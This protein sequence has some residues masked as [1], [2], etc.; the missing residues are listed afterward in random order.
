M[1]A[2]ND[3]ESLSFDPGSMTLTSCM[4]QGNQF[5]F[6]VTPAKSSVGLHYCR[7][8]FRRRS[9][10][11][12]SLR[13]CCYGWFFGSV[14]ILDLQ[15]PAEMPET[16]RVKTSLKYLWP[17]CAM[18]FLSQM[19]LCICLAFFDESGKV[20]LV[21]VLLTM[22]PFWGTM[23]VL[24][25]YSWVG[26]YVERLTIDGTRISLR[27]IWQDHQFDVSQL[28]SLTWTGFADSIF[29]RCPDQ[30]LRLYWS[31]YSKEDQ[32]RI[33]ELLR[34]IV[35][36]SV[37]EGWPMFCHTV[38]LP[39]R[40]GT[41]FRERVHPAS[42][43]YTVT[44][45]RYD[46]V[47]VVVIPMA[48]LIALTIGVW[49]NQWKAFVPPACLVFV[50]LLVRFGIPKEGR[51]ELRL[52][53]MR[54]FPI[55]AALLGFGGIAIGFLLIGVLPLGGVGKTTATAVGMV[56][57]GMGFVAMLYLVYKFEKKQQLAN[58]QA[59]ISAPEQW[60]QGV[61]HESDLEQKSM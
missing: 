20:N 18:F 27:S 49:F 40:D 23:F 13:A 58:E 34:G 2:R 52:A 56:T 14:A 48:F 17:F 55:P 38:A 3:W 16:F 37:Q 44:R 9:L 53:K 39:L 43:F 29:F 32:L 47:A 50:W 36:E 1:P 6:D 24:S 25:I 11:W 4:R 54:P 26:C 8:T 21:A 42:D 30:K 46:R 19:I 41:S 31:N 33:I 15:E 35:P 59:A 28:E 10:D 22:V 60:R 61:D 51:K 45:Q 57:M 7:C 12:Q 5:V